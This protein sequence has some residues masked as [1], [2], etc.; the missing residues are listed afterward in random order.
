MAVYTKISEADLNALLSRYSIGDLIDFKGITEGVENTNYKVDTTEGHYIL[1]I[2]EKRVN[3]ADL[4]FFITLKTHLAVSGIP[5][6]QPI[7]DRDGKVLQ[8]LGGKPMAIVSFL[9]GTWTREPSADYCY[10]VGA[11]LADIHAA[12]SDF[13]MHRA[14][15]LGHQSWRGLWEKSI[16]FADTLEDGLKEK[17]VSYLDRL[18]QEWPSDLPQGVIH[19]DLFPDNVLFT[20]DRISGIID[21]YFACNGL[22]A[23]DL[24]I[25]IN[26]WCFDAAG[27]FA[28]NKSAAMIEGYES[29]RVLTESEVA[30]LPTLARGSAM[31]FFLTRLYDWINTP[32]DA[33]VQPHDPMDYRRRLSFHDTAHDSSV[34]GVKR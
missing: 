24:G 30:A 27:T 7:A 18:D 12:G 31:R 6:P 10:Q 20:D 9:E 14:N 29:I 5:C 13:T 26:A 8:E 33:Q 1:T 4:P 25:T 11:A 22:F 15:A 2:Y 19:A 23:Y 34:Y 17:I 16:Y 3:R 32:Q 28:Q 21:F